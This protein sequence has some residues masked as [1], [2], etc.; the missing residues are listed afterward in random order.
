VRVGE[1]GGLLVADADDQRSVR[2]GG[3]DQRQRED[4]QRTAEDAV[5][6]SREPSGVD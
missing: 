6:C 3:G 5:E 1:V 4:E 2:G